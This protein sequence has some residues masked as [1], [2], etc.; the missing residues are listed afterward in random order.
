MG[1][2]LSDCQDRCDEECDRERKCFVDQ[3]EVKIGAFD[4]MQYPE[5]TR[6]NHNIGQHSFVNEIAASIGSARSNQSS[7]G[8]RARLRPQ[9]VTWADGFMRQTSNLLN[10]FQLRPKASSFTSAHVGGHDRST[11][12]LGEQMN[13]V[14]GYP[15]NPSPPSAYLR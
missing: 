11:M 2:V 5:G 9:P 4:M 6:I 13:M 7:D 8:A 10:R 3:N 12:T 15:S 1:A 14:R